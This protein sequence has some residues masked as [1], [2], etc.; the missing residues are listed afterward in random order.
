M[1]RSSSFTRID[2]WFA[3]GSGQRGGLA[4][5][6]AFGHGVASAA[7]TRSTGTVTRCTHT[8]TCLNRPTGVAPQASGERRWRSWSGSSLGGCQNLPAKRGQTRSSRPD[9][10]R[11]EEGPPVAWRPKLQT[12]RKRRL[13]LAVVRALDEEHVGRDSADV[14]GGSVTAGR[15]GCRTCGPDLASPSS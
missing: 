2:L 14:A 13:V 12:R 1:N 5:I 4:A 8:R 10:R 15:G 7:G 9:G 11:A 3:A 6:I